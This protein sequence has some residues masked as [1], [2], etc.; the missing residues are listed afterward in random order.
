[1]QMKLAPRREVAYTESGGSKE[2]ISV[3]ITTRADGS[4]EIS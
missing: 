3:L 2:Q 4:H 1:M